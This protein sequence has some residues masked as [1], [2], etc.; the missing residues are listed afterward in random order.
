[1]LPPSVT[2]EEAVADAVHVQENTP[3]VLETKIK[4]FQTLD[5]AAHPDAVLSSSTSALLPS[6]FTE[7]LRGRGRCIV[8]HPINPP[9][10]IPAA[11]VVRRLIAELEEARQRLARL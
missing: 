2:L 8:V 1:M 4:V 9:Y 10:L 7:G 6:R 3:E 11:E 5:A